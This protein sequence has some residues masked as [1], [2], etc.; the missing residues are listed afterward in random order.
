MTESPYHLLAIFKAKIPELVTT[1]LVN[2]DGTGVLQIMRATVY[3]H[4]PTGY[5][6][7]LRIILLLAV[8]GYRYDLQAQLVSVETGVIFESTGFYYSVQ[9]F[10]AM[11]WVS[12]VSWN[13]L[14]GIS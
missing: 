14:S 10:I 6:Y 4:P 5:V 7:H 8:H 13:K 2:S 12:K 1:L 9:Q 11:P 3:N